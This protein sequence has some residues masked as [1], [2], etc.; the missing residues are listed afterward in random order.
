LEKVSTK[1]GKVSTAPKNHE[2]SD[3]DDDNEEG[4]S[5]LDQVFS[6]DALPERSGKFP[7]LS[8]SLAF[9]KVL[10]QADTNHD[11]G[12]RQGTDLA[13]HTRLPLLAERCRAGMPAA[14]NV[15][16]SLGGKA[17]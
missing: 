7:L 14:S 15:C 8:L 17:D 6:A 12:R 1:D 9:F 11:A 2:E 13:P 5:S 4:N 10:S 16:C 3:D